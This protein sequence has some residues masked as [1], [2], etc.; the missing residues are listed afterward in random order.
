M[1]PFALILFLLLGSFA[2]AGA[3]ACNL[4]NHCPESEPCCDQYGICGTGYYCLG[5]CDVRFSYNLSACMPM[6]RMTSFEESFA[7][8]DTIGEITSYLGNA[9]A[10]DWVY[11]GYIDTYDDALLIQMPNG[12]TGTVVSSTKYL[13][14][15]KVGATLKSSR[16]KGVV[17]A[18]ITFSDVK[19]EIDF[20]FVGYDLT[21]PQSNFYALGITNYSN[22]ENS[23]TTNTFSN[24]HYYEIDWQEDELTW[25]IDG[26][27]IRTL[28]KDDTWNST[29]ERYDYPQTPSRIEMSLWPG[30]DSSNGL[31]TIEWAGG[32]ISWDTEDIKEYGY[33][34]AY[35][36]NMTVEAY[37][38]P[39]FVEH[40]DLNST[41]Y[42]AFVYN[43]TEDINEN[44]ILLSTDK[45]WLGS[46]DSTG[47]DP[48]NEDEETVETTKIVSLSGSVL[49]TKTTVKTLTHPKATTSSTS[50]T[51]TSAWTGGFV[52]DTET[53]STA[54]N[55]SKSGS[56]S[57]GAVKSTTFSIVAG[58]IVGAL[59]VFVF[60][61]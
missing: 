45:T 7:S 21:H 11:T 44:N 3:I 58:A 39:D 43:S 13:W 4:T 8:L 10:Y 25:L 38:L 60:G 61:L 30:G 40:R 2:S 53:T 9:S 59:G 54:S 14:Y 52:Q 6:P 16:D 5:G 55:S 50:T 57:S 24:W 46:E 36:K 26:Q 41:K 29:T 15:G 20:E 33:Y 42:H 34:Y 51:S 1:R 35:V 17:T 12:T 22:A 28:K 47:F 37:D 56:S 49:M 31:G 27:V 18:F 48:D 32:E 19:D 23:T